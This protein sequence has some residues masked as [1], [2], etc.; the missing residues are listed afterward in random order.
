MLSVILVMS[1]AIIIAVGISGQTTDLEDQLISVVGTVNSFDGPTC[2][3]QALTT[4]TKNEKPTL[5][6]MQY[7]LFLLRQFRILQRPT[8]RFKLRELQVL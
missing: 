3:S 6:E 7:L 2:V 8:K 1:T 5:Q 4:P